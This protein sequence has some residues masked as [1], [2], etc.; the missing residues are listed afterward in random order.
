M[1]IIEGQGDVI[2]RDVRRTYDG[3][4]LFTVRLYLIF[5]TGDVYLL[6]VCTLVTVP[7]IRLDRNGCTIVPYYQTYAESN[8][9]CITKH[10]YGLLLYAES[11]RT[12]TVGI[13]IIFRN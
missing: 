12:I 2:V 6:V 4:V 10:L 7:S 9:Y 1:N 3:C 11:I 13:I 8:L 5:G